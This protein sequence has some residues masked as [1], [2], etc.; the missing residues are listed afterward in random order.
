MDY[1]MIICSRM[2]QELTRAGEIDE[3]ELAEGGRAID[4]V[5]SPEGQRKRGEK[6]GGQ[7]GVKG[8]G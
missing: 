3:V 8:G 7:R 2:L 4:G 1:T 6:W 5:L